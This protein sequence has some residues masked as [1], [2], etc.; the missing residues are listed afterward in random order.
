MGRRKVKLFMSAFQFILE[1]RE[2]VSKPLKKL[3][4]SFE[5][6]RKQGKKVNEVFEGMESPLKKA[7][8]TADGLKAKFKEVNK[9]LGGLPALVAGAFAV[10]KI[11]SF[12]GAVVDTLAEFERF[13]AVLTNTLGSNS[14]AQKALKQITVFAN[15]TPFQ[16]NELSDSFVKLANQN[17]T[18][19]M[20]EMTQLGDLA[21]AVG[22]DFG[23]LTDAL[24]SGRV[25]EMESLKNFGITAKKEGDK[26]A[27]S[28]RGQETII[29]A[30]AK[31]VT[32]YVLSLGKLNGVQGASAAIAKT[33]GG[34]LSNLEGKFIELKLEIGEKLKPVIEAVIG[35]MSRMVDKLRNL[36][37]WIAANQEAFLYWLGILGKV[38]GAVLSVIAAM[39]I[40]GLIKTV[41]AAVTT[42]FVFLKN[43][44]I[45][46]KVAMLLFNA[47]FLA[48]P[49]GQVIA[50]VVALLAGLWGL[51]KLF[52]QIGEAIS[53]FY[54]G[55]VYWFGK[56][57]DWVYNTFIN[58][59]F[60]SL[61]SVG[62]FFGI[63]SEQKVDPIKSESIDALKATTKQIKELD[64]G[65]GDN[66]KGFTPNVK[67][68]NGL[69]QKENKRN[70]VTSIGKTQK[71]KGL[72]DVVAPKGSVN[73][74]VI[75]IGKLVEAMN[76]YYSGSTKE[77]PTD[78]KQ[79]LTKAMVQAVNNVYN[80]T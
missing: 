51:T 59:L 72:S 24:I 42:A 9:T 74:T 33:T 49:I 62:E 39:K 30:N 45:A 6:V 12:G 76:F 26:I 68:P 27:L 57:K 8:S 60:E 73:N 63:L 52:P 35:V 44:I 2:K 15:Q 10:N 16:I 22:K 41:L 14:A 53:S 18:P 20:Q 78:V 17:F 1:L 79:E 13:E 4:A 11:T 67:M 66:I 77:R 29:D 80:G 34:Q 37:N 3:S 32:D 23:Q 25:M 50:A 48:N 75:K 40:F 5:V 47:V 7:S 56:A 70:P 71:V 38:T 43:G 19:T 54:D 21:S 65:L 28:F 36:V 58:P 55:V 46:V 64:L 31:A 69:G 61:R